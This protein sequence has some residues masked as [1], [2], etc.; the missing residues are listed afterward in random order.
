MEAVLSFVVVAQFGKTTRLKTPRIES[1]GFGGDLQLCRARVG[2][3]RVHVTDAA[4]RIKKSQVERCANEP[5]WAFIFPILAL[6]H[7]GHVCEVG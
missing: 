7:N 4:R 6:L 1:S 2:V 5:E 3:A